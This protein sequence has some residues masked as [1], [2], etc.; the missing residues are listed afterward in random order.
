MDPNNS[1]IN[2]DHRSLIKNLVIE[3]QQHVFLHGPSGSGK[4]TFLNLLSGIVKPVSGEIIINQTDITKLSSVQC[5]QFRAQN[6]SIIFQQFNLIPYLSLI[7]NVKLS[8]L[9]VKNHIKDHNN[10]YSSHH[11]AEQLLIKLGINRELF[12]KK[13]NQISVGQQQRVAVARALHSQG[14][15]ILADEP[16]SA[17]DHK[18]KHDFIKLLFSTLKKRS[19]TLIFVSHDLTIGDYFDHKIE[20]QK[21]WSN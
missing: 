5:D 3:N 15:L 20:C 4:S 1:N 12:T 21:L 7:E 13:A 10:Q 9:F 11:S 8:R 16:T 2:D 18:S 19:A 17:L 6:I 14:K